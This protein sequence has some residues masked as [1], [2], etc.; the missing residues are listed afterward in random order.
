MESKDRCLTTWPLPN[1]GFRPGGRQRHITSGSISGLD[2][3]RCHRRYSVMRNR[4]MAWPLCAVLL[5]ACGSTTV[6]TPN[7]P[8]PAG[9]PPVALA[10]VDPG[11]VV[12]SPATGPSQVGPGF[13]ALPTPDPQWTPTREAGA[14]LIPVA[15]ISEAKG[16][17]VS[18]PGGQRQDDPRSVVAL[19]GHA[20]GAIGQN[21]GLTFVVAKNLWVP[22]PF[23]WVDPT[24]A[25]YAYDDFSG[26]G[27]VAVT[28]PGQVSRTLAKG[29]WNVLGADNGGVYATRVQQPGAWF[30][31]FAPGQGSQLLVDHGTWSKYAAGALWSAEGG[32]L[33]RHDLSSGADTSWAPQVLA[34]GLLGFDGSGNPI[35]S[36]PP[37]TLPAGSLELTVARSDG[38]TTSLWTANGLGV[39]LAIGDSTGI[40]W[41]AG[42]GNVGAPGHGLYHWTPAPGAQ[43]VSIPEANLGGPCV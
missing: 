17:F 8:V 11:L 30:V 34:Y 16:W 35:V 36:T 22:V 6:A 43:I 39:N 24:G 23:N 2:T 20:P 27:I 1:L 13:I 18:Y 28:I 26:D 32:H 38:S 14:C 29:A 9:S 40:W 42:G 41:E 5:F 3:L 31:P 25:F 37:A 15:D 21:Y 10:P 7:G 4:R 33:L 12:T 19:P